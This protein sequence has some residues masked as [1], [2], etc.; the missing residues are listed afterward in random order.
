MDSETT[1]VVRLIAGA[2]GLVAVC[3]CVG[4]FLLGG[5]SSGT[6]TTNIAAEPVATPSPLT[7]QASVSPELSVVET[8]S[9][10][11]ASAPASLRV[12]TRRTSEE[13]TPAPQPTALPKARLTSSSD[14]SEGVSAPSSATSKTKKTGEKSHDD[15]VQLPAPD[16]EKKPADPDTTAAAEG[17]ASEAKPTEPGSSS[18]YRVRV[19]NSFGSH[20]DADQ[21]ASELKGRGFA[22]TVMPSGKG[23]FQVQIG[24]YK[25]K[26]HAEDKQK[27]LEKNNYDTH[28]SDKD[29]D[30]DNAKAKDSEAKPKSEEKTD[31]K[32]ADG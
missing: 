6:P 31:K 29:G 20:D 32:T 17:A 5:R 24:A 11:R 18:L 1:P 9:T 4:F 13:A 25:D 2:V 26:K 21:L 14:T 16:E 3:F 8:T 22:A 30:S 15:A 12:A 7:V 19:K 23:K 27:E 10:K 28:I